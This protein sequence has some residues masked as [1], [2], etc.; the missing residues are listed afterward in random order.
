MLVNKENPSIDN[1]VSLMYVGDFIEE[2]IKVINNE[3]EINLNK[4]LIYNYNV[5]DVLTS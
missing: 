2:I 5:S 3:D 1:E 4:N